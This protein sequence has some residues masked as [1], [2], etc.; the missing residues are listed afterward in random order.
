MW[1]AI[2]SDLFD[3]V[4]TIQNDTSKTL[5][6]VLGEDEEEE[7]ENDQHLLDKLAADVR[8]SYETY[9]KPLKDHKAKEFEKYKKKF[10]LSSYAKEIAQVLDE[11]TEVSRFYAELV[12]IEISPEEFWARLFFRLHLL[13]RTGSATFE[14]DEDD[15]EEL[16][17]EDTEVLAPN[18]DDSAPVGISSALSNDEG[19]LKKMNQLETENI[20]LKNEIA[21]LRAKVAELQ[22][23]LAQNSIVATPMSEEPITPEPVVEVASSSGSEPNETEKPPERMNSMSQLETSSLASSDGSIMLVKHKDI[24][25]IEETQNKP[26]PVSTVQETEKAKHLASLDDDEDEDGWS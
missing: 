9:A 16:V 1:S 23:L 18:G 22:H 11:E 26:Q 8:R 20:S 21:Q 17:W 13:T 6:K 14:D 24:A 12:P 4:N 19:L 25:L 3:F 10:S 2:K 7:N 5:T 15:E